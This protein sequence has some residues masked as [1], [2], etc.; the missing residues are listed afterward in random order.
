MA[1]LY[2]VHTSCNRSSCIVPTRIVWRACNLVPESGGD[3]T[4]RRQF[5]E[6]SDRLRRINPG[7]MVR[8]KPDPDEMKGKA[9]YPIPN[10]WSSVTM[11]STTSTGTP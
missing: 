4:A 9:A 8:A 10:E 6:T 11:R 2:V 3:V 1:L 7:L 5:Q